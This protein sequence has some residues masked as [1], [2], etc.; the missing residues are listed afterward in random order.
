[1]NKISKK[2][3]SLVTM[4]A[5]ALTLVPAAAFAQAGQV[6]GSTVTVNPVSEN[7]DCKRRQGS[8]RAY[9]GDHIEKGN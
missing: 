8:L 5:F 9:T 6:D 2:I 3:V 4:A 1:M 7:S